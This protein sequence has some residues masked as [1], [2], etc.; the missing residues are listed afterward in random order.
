MTEKQ[1]G[2]TIY[3]AF[4]YHS[5]ERGA[6]EN[7]NGLLRQFFPK[8]SVFAT[9]TQKNIQKAVR[10][11][12]NRPRKRLNYSTPYEIFNQKEKCCSLE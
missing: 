9:I 11:L 10:L 7:A 8:K 3:F 6:N 12:N 2:L 4:P 5:W 1:T